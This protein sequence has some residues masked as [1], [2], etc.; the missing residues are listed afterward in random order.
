MKPFSK[1]VRNH[2]SVLRDLEALGSV[3]IITEGE[4]VGRMQEVE[5]LCEALRIDR[6]VVTM[7]ASQSSCLR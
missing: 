5:K 6:W 3:H 7:A 1:P 4:A 2:T